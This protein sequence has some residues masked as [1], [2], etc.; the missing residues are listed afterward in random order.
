MEALTLQTC[1]ERHP[2]SASSL[3]RWPLPLA[4]QPLQQSWQRPPSELQTSEPQLLSSGQ[5]SA[6][7]QPVQ[8]DQKIFPRQ[9]HASAFLSKTLS[10]LA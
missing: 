2:S 5:Q 1:S 6:P 3:P 8:G 4:L 10:T 9:A 7:L